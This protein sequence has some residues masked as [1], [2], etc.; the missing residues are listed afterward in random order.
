[1]L[2]GL[3]LSAIGRQAATV[4]K[5]SEQQTFE[6]VDMAT[7]TKRDK[8]EIAALEA[9]YAVPAFKPKHEQFLGGI[10]AMNTGR[11][12]GILTVIFMAKALGF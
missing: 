8:Q 2:F 4:K 5:I 1:M 6:P 11:L 9:L 7:L 3:L 12:F 10:L